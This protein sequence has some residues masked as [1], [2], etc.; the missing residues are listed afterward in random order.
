M[1]VLDQGIHCKKP[2]KFVAVVGKSPEEMSGLC[3]FK[4]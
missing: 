4:R 1:R 3:A 2:K